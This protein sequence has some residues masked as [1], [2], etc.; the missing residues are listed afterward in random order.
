LKVFCDRHH[1]DLTYSLKLLFENR[2]GHEIYFPIGL[3]WFTSGFWRI[4]E[5]YGNAQDTINQYLSTTDTVFDQYKS[6]NG[7]YKL[8]DDIYHVFDPSHND[9]IKCITFEKFK[10]MQFDIV[11]SSVPAHDETYSQLIRE[12][13]PKAKHIVQMGNIGQTTPYKNV[14]HTI[15][16]S[17]SPNQN[18]VY[19]HQEIDPIFFSYPPTYPQKKRI[20]SFVNLLPYPEIWDEYFLNLPEFEMKAFGAGCPDGSV[21]GAHGIAPLMQEATFGWYVKPFGGF[22]HNFMNWCSSGRPLIL[23]GSLNEDYALADPSILA[24]YEDGVTCI[25]LDKRNIEDNIKMIR[26]FTEPEKNMAMGKELQ[27]RFKEV[28]NYDEDEI[29]IRNFLNNLL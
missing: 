17:S 22:G 26:E 3:D 14:M 9:W 13:M 1:G 12:F 28:V 8:E 10:Q 2:L 11:I 15:P 18:T 24:L 25:D 27:K 6:I 20:Y 7:N 4:A 16:F 5:P 21:S 19:Y 29:K 23:K